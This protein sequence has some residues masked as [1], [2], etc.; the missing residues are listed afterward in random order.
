LATLVRGQA[1]MLCSLMAVFIPHG[2]VQPRLEKTSGNTP[3]R[4]PARNTCTH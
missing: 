2:R 4:G 1:A 3:P